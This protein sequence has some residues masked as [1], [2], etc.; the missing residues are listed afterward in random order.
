M[1]TIGF[2][3]EP[4]AINFAVVEGTTQAPRLIA[5]DTLKAP[6]SYEEPACLAGCIT[7]MPRADF[8]VCK[9]AVNH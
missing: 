3:A 1:P 6:V 2:R 9:R 7:A 5:A 8:G 4:T